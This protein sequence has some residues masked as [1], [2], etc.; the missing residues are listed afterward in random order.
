M[1]SADL[2]PEI[3]L[4]QLNIDLMELV[5]Q[6]IAY[7]YYKTADVQSWLMYCTCCKEHFHITKS[8]NLKVTE[9]T[10]CP[11]CR[12]SVQV[13][14]YIEDRSLENSIRTLN[15]KFLYT[16]FIKEPN[17]A[18][19]FKTYKC[20]YNFSGTPGEEYI[21]FLEYDLIYLNFGEV[22]RWCKGYNSFYGE[23]EWREV[24]KITTPS[25]WTASNSQYK[26]KH[27]IDEINTENT[28]IKYALSK[29]TEQLPLMEYLE[30][31]IK[32]PNIEL[33][34]KAGYVNWVK[35]YFS[36]FK[37]EFRKVINLKSQTFK[38][39]FKNLNKTEINEL[40]MHTII[41]VSTYLKLK[42]IQFLKIVDSKTI[43]IVRLL[44]RQNFLKRVIDLSKKTSLK[45]LQNYL[46][47]QSK[48]NFSASL[49]DTLIDYLDYISQLERLDIRNPEYFPSNLHL[50]HTRLS[51]RITQIEKAKASLGGNVAFRIIRKKLK[52]T[53]F[54]YKGLI[55]RPIDSL[56]ELILEGEQNANCVADLGYKNKHT[57]G[58]FCVFVMREAI[59]CK[60]S[61][62]TV[63]FD[64]KTNEIIQCRGRG[65]RKLDDA[66]ESLKDEF[67][68]KWLVHLEKVHPIKKKKKVG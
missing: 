67:I 57:Q 34:I 49:C 61:L 28:C 1:L 43:T 19:W 16:H 48:K 35:G 21:D 29:E 26:Y 30:L 18:V 36:G 50:Q 27:I 11:Q 3:D 64:T 33:L 62:Y 31:Y 60:N 63:E 59:N 42:E 6:D 12:S 2:C 58:R 24:R 38:G 9:Y 47:T 20:F 10:E 66:I 53:T 40:K 37:A 17:G 22:R 55:I 7:L 41:D 56:N 5:N 51:E 46:T 65:N 8:R 45:N 68:E 32:N 15:Y 39:L 44:N 14:R 54:K 13:K 52:N 4:E 25:W 23:T